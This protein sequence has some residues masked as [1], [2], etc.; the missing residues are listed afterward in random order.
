M[1][2]NDL[3]RWIFQIPL[4]DVQNEVFDDS[5]GDKVCLLCGKE[6]KGQNIYYVHLTNECNLISS[7]EE[8]DNS[9]GAFPIGANCRKRLPNNFYWK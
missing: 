2:K 9:Q 4:E 3:H 8:F 1:K 5:K 6:L 7:P